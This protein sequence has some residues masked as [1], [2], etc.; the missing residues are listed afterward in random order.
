MRLVLE[1][2]FLPDEITPHPPFEYELKG[3]KHYL[4]L[5]ESVGSRSE[6]TVIGGV[7][8]KQIDVVVTK[9]SIG[10]VLAVSFKGTQ[11]AFRNLT[12]RMEEA[13]GDCTNIH[14]A[15]PSLVYGFYHIIL[16]NRPSQIGKH[17]LVGDQ[18]D[19]SVSNTGDI[20]PQVQRYL[21]AIQALSG[22]KTQWEDPSSYEAVALHFVESSADRIS[23]T[24]GAIPDDSLLHRDL[25]F[26]KL[27][28]TYDVRYPYM[29]ERV[30]EAKRVRWER[31][32]P[33]AETLESE[34]GDSIEEI[35][36]YAPRFSG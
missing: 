28:E 6:R 25:F 30:S 20:E 7:R 14:L 13:V 21:L 35:L 27:L 10:P 17:R 19:V 31:E 11:K 1:G 9:P 2:G 8:S 18:N 15:Y 36:G 24:F 5:D 23:E 29:A 33:L 22:R 34:F 26:G 4:T 3:G 16:A 12:N 32:S